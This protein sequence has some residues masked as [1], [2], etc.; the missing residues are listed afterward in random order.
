MGTK[1]I[2]TT[3]GTSLIGN[4]K[5]IYNS[6]KLYKLEDYEEKEKS[7]S[8]NG[9][10]NFKNCLEEKRDVKKKLKEFAFKNFPNASAELTS[11]QK[12]KEKYPNEDFI[13]Y[14]LTSD[15]FEGYFVGEILKEVLEEKNFQVKEVKYI[16]HFNVNINDRDLI[17]KGYKE[18]IK[19]IYGKVYGYSEI[20][21]ITGGY[22]A[23]IP[24]MTI[25]SSI[26]KIPLVYLFESS[27]YLIE[28]PPAPFKLDLSIIEKLKEVFEYIEENTGIEENNP[29]LIKVKNTLSPQEQQQIEYLFE[30]YEYNILTT[31]LIG[32]ILWEEFKEKQEI[33]LGKCNLGYE[34][35]INNS[36]WGRHH[37]N[38]K[39]EKFGKKLLKNKYV[40]KIIN[41]AEYEPNKNNFIV[42]IEP[43]NQTGVIKIK[44]PSEIYTL[45]VQTTGKNKKETFEIAK[46]LEE[47]YGG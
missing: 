20:L 27:E 47:E 29:L 12:L 9:Y 1:V 5:N 30:E 46:I 19:Y 39:V 16:D 3:V 8:N 41:S 38:D 45:L 15:T 24:V 36:N 10:E 40:C 26:K 35:K 17:K 31:S 33:K 22:K 11:L 14:L 23:F 18:L 42:E 13:I 21:N 44:I 37:G 25:I 32:D 4:F 6:E 2:I 28:V 34:Q 43:Q 7:V